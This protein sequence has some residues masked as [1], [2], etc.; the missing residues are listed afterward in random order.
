MGTGRDPF[1][2]KYHGKATLNLK[3][4][5][6]CPRKSPGLHTGHCHWDIWVCWTWCWW[7]W[8][9]WCP[10]HG[11]HE[12]GGTNKV[13]A[14]SPGDHPACLQALPPTFT[15]HT[16]WTPSQPVEHLFS[17]EHPLLVA[18]TLSLGPN[19]LDFVTLSSMS[20][21]LKE[22]CSGHLLIQFCTD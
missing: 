10:A 13:R 4:S 14:S 11:A 20:V 19:L 16:P 3:D 5:T 1:F 21:I 2:A 6:N 8:C 15:L 22:I 18:T 7:P 9:R 17:C 12:G